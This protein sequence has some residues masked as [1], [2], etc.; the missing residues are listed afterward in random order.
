MRT[1]DDIVARA[2]ADNRGVVLVP[3]S[4][5]ARDL[6]IATAA[7][8][9]VRLKQLKPKPHAID[10]VEMLPAIGRLVAAIPAI[11]FMWLSD[12]VDLGRGAGS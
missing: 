7:A 2:E 4:E 5:P 8:A 12:G 10:R 3:L 1:A 9:R 11:D 6:S